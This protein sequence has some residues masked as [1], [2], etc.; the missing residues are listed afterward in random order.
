MTHLTEEKAA[1]SALHSESLPVNHASHKQ[2]TFYTI[3]Q[4]GVGGSQGEEGGGGSLV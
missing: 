2:V 1:L 3:P 4:A